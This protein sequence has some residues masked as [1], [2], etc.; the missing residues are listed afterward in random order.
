MYDLVE[1]F[2]CFIIKFGI[3]VKEVGEDYKILFYKVL[4]NFNYYYYILIIYFWILE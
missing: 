4:F 3:I 2:F 1:D